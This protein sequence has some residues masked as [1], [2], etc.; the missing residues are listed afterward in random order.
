MPE[1]ATPLIEALLAV[2]DAGGL[3]LPDF[4]A[5][6]ERSPRVGFH[7]I[8]YLQARSLGGRQ[9]GSFAQRRPLSGAPK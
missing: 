2:I 6:S 1:A 8:G 7:D 9:G 5:L 4:F 3:Y